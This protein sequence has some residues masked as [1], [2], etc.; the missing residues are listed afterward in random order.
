MECKSLEG[1]QKA[2]S[3]AWLHHGDHPS[4]TMT[5]WEI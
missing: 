2:A 1:L 5:A 3:E 4:D